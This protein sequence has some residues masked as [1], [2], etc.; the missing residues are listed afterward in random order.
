MARSYEAK[1]SQLIMFWLALLYRMDIQLR[2][3]LFVHPQAKNLLSLRTSFYRYK[4]R[5]VEER[6]WT[7]YLKEESDVAQG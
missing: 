7:D 5:V 3:R 1:R 6:H 4:R 2:D